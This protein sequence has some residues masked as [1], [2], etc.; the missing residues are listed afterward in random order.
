MTVAKFGMNLLYH[1][2]VLRGNAVC[3]HQK[4][5]VRVEWLRDGHQLVESLAV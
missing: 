1:D 2:T 5:V 4:A 3:V